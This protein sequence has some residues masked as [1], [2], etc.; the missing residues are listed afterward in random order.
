MI[1]NG[2][3]EDQEFMVTRQTWGE[4]LE[5]GKIYELVIHVGMRSGNGDTTNC[6][7]TDT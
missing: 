6:N 4:L 7:K 5:T 3:N 1:D 2:E